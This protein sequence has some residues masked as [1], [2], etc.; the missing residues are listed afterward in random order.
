M[1][2]TSR[3][4]ALGAGRE[5]ALSRSRQLLPLRAPWLE[6]VH[7]REELLR[8]VLTSSRTSSSSEVVSKFDFD[9]VTAETLARLPYVLATRAAY[10]SE[11]P[12]GY[13]A[14][15]PQSR[16]TLWRR[17]SR[18]SVACPARPTPS[19]GASAAAAARRPP[20]SRPSPRP[21]VW[22]RPRVVVA[23]DRGRRRAAPRSS[24]ICRRASG[25][26]RSSTT[27]PASS[28]IDGPG[29]DATL[30]GQP[31]LPRSG[32][33]LRRRL[34]RERRRRAGDDHRDRRGRRRRRPAARCAARSPT[35]ARVAATSTK[36]RSESCGDYVDWYEPARPSAAAEAASS[37][38]AS[39]RKKSLRVTTAWT[40]P[41]GR[42]RDDQHAVVQEELGELGVGVLVLDDD[43]V[44]GQVLA[45]RL[46]RAR[47][48]ALD[49]LVD[50]ARDH[51][52]GAELAHV[53]GK[54]R[55]HELALAEDAGE[56]AVL[57]RPRAGP[58]SPDS[59]TRLTRGRRSARRRA[60]G[61]ISR[62]R[63]FDDRVGHRASIALRSGAT[64]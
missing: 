20:R 26:S 64:T 52:R 31:R 10:A 19:P 45:D 59:T 49:R 39:S 32:A 2:G 17:G 30:P 12:P 57:A 14:S 7:R 63:R 3:D 11:P 41:L 4:P 54:Q 35:S 53:A 46:E 29:L 48:A 28:T 22:P 42:D 62:Q 40:V 27:P 60:S 34:D 36:P 8:P 33:V 18:R 47:L 56:A 6:A 23:D 55:G 61:S 15:S 21:P 16:T 9:S 43:V 50:R 1:R 37:F 13:E 38:S 5:A 51:R 44:G 24:S 25:I 58:G